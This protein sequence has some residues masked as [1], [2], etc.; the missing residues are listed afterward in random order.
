MLHRYFAV[1]VHSDRGSNIYR[2]IGLADETDKTHIPRAGAW[3]DHLILTTEN[4]SDWV[5]TVELT[6]SP[7]TARYSVN[8][9]LAVE[10]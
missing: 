9:A 8:C 6:L 2:I 3:P 1:R 10:H 7:I 4:E 5:P